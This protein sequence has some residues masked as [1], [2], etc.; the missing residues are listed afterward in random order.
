MISC[1]QIKIPTSGWVH[2]PGSLER[3]PPARALPTRARGSAGLSESPSGPGDPPG[4]P[5][6]AWPRQRCWGRRH[7]HRLPCGRRDWFKGEKEPAIETRQRRV[8]EEKSIHEATGASRLSR[9]LRPCPLTPGPWEG[10]LHEIRAPSSWLKTR[11]R[12]LLRQRLRWMRA[13]SRIHP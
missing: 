13:S 11:C 9:D 5:A 3:D 2:H 1:V 12:Y 8:G 4:N 6:A 7:R 10:S